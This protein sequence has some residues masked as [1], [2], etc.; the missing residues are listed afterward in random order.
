MQH[1]LLQHDDYPKNHG[2][3]AHDEDRKPNV[4]GSR[5]AGN[6]DMQRRR[7]EPGLHARCLPTK[8]DSSD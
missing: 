7:L 1:V 3:V 2:E 8:H 4:L 6:T 5:G